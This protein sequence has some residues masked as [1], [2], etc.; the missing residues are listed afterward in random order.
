V[1]V[2]ININGAPIRAADAEA[3]RTAF[4]AIYVAKGET[5]VQQQ[6]NRK[7]AFH[8]NV[9]KAQKENLIGVQVLPNGQTLLWLATADTT[10]F[11]YNLQREPS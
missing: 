4:Y 6:D 1:T 3:V 7:H 9:D 2:N 5:K 8:R 11:E 10:D